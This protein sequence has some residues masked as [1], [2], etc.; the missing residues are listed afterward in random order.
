MT[1]TSVTIIGP[2]AIPHIGIRLQ[3]MLEDGWWVASLRLVRFVL[4]YE[5]SVKNFFINGGA[6]LAGRVE[7]CLLEWSSRVLLALLVAHFTAAF[8]LLNYICAARLLRSWWLLDSMT[9]GLLHS[10]LS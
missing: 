5:F 8:Q 9:E 6:R 3:I 10:F 2:V 4:P 7:A 1:I